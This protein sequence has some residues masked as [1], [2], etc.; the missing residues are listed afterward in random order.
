MAGGAGAASGFS[1]LQFLGGSREGCLFDEG[2]K[3][4]EEDLA[5]VCHEV[6]GVEVEPHDRAFLSLRDLGK[7]EEKVVA[8][9]SVAQLRNTKLDSTL[10]LRLWAARDESAVVDPNSRRALGELRI[11][12]RRLVDRDLGMFYQTWLTLD[13]PGLME[14]VA[15]LEDDGSALE[16]RLLDGPRDLTKARICLSLCREIDLGSSGK[17]ALT[18]DAPTGTRLAQWSPLL[19]SHEQHVAMSATLHAQST[20]APMPKQPLPPPRQPASQAGEMSPAELAELKAQNAQRQAEILGV[21][22]EIEQ[23]QLEANE[24]IEAA[25]D[26]IKG[27]KQERDNRKAEADD[28]VTEGQ[29]LRA[30]R[31]ELGQEVS[32]LAEEKEQLL[33]IVED[34]HQ[35]CMAAGLPAG[36]HSMDSIRHSFG[37]T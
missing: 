4:T 16:Q 22:Q 36:R 10:L 14:A 3:K 9:S 23:L 25:N 21:K 27:L 5:A 37:L 15:G 17:L 7:R 18:T 30:R 33:R 2:S 29:R 20:G 12:I 8:I 24:K 31:Q 28:L 19:R 13:P 11:P 34:L 35:S 32:R 1:L 26:R 6:R